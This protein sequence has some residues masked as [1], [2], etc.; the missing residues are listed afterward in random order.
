MYPSKNA[1]SDNDRTVLLARIK[2]LLVRS[3]IVLN[4]VIEPDGLPLPMPPKSTHAPPPALG[5]RAILTIV[6]SVT[7]SSIP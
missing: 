6:E 3:V 4:E 1:V 2:A 5:P 7:P